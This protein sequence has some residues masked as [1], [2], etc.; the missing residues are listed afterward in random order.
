MSYKKDPT[1]IRVPKLP[2][3][4]PPLPIVKPI[5]ENNTLSQVK[6]HESNITFHE[7]NK[8]VNLAFDTTN[9]AA[10]L[11]IE[12]EYGERLRYF[13]KLLD[14]NNNLRAVFSINHPI[15]PIVQHG[16][17]C[18]LVALAMAGSKLCKNRHFSV[19]DL[20]DYSKMANYTKHGEM[21]SAYQLADVAVECLNLDANV[22]ELSSDIQYKLLHFILQGCMI[23]VP[24]DKDKN[25]MPCSERGHHAHWG[26]ITGFVFN[27]IT[28]FGGFH[29]IVPDKMIPNV[30][31]L[32][33]TS[34]SEMELTQVDQSTIHVLIRHGKSKHL[35]LWP[36]NL[37]LESNSNLK[38]VCPDMDPDLWIFPQEKEGLGNV[39]GSKLIVL[40]PNL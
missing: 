20:L 15:E 19:Q 25:H 30:Y 3:N 32:K 38:E 11:D 40:K 31:H 23:L 14:A 10:L 39:L 17:M 16:P 29:D 6:Q 27:S 12:K 18:G 9:I 35:A 28:E 37:L 34:L 2:P 22:I 33:G 7:L 26:V 13:V 21:F 4:P 5:S 24:Y 8:K 36:L 1:Q